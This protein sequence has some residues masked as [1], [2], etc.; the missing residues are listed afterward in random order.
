MLSTFTVIS[1]TVFPLLYIVLQ[2]VE[3]S[4]DLAPRLPID[5]C[6]SKLIVYRLITALFICD[7]K[8]NSNQNIM[9]DFLSAPFVSSNSFYFQ[10]KLNKQ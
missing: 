4:V 2:L 1:E 8:V 3:K 7:F 10:N 6:R 5:K 9:C